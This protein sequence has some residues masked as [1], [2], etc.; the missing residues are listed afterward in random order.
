MFLH[1]LPVIL[2]G[3]LAVTLKEPSPMILLSGQHVMLPVK[4]GPE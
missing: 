3:F 4:W 1:E 2:L